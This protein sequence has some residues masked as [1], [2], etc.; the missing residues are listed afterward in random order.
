M[1]QLEQEYYADLCKNSLKEHLE[2]NNF[3]TGDSI[4]CT[5]KGTSS[6]LIKIAE[7]NQ[8]VF[9]FDGYYAFIDEVRKATKEEIQIG[10]R[11]EL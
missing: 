2:K 11:I 9:Y 5:T 7:Q 1:N 3:K 6:T 4:V 10:Q 8:D